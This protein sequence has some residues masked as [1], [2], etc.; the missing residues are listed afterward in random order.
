MGEYPRLRTLGESRMQA[1]KNSWITLM[2]EYTWFVLG[3]WTFVNGTRAT[4]IKVPQVT[5]AHVPRNS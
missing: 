3:R 1:Q 5:K 2:T 4:V